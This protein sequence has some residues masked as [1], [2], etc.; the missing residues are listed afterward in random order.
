MPPTGHC[1]P[2]DSY[3]PHHTLIISSPS[4]HIIS[5]IKSINLS[6]MERLAYMTT[7]SYCQ[8]MVSC[9]NCQSMV[10][11]FNLAACHRHSSPW[12]KTRTQI[13][14]HLSTFIMHQYIQEEHHHHNWV[15]TTATGHRTWWNSRT[16]QDILH[17]KRIQFSLHS[18]VHGYHP[19]THNLQSQLWRRREN[20]NIIHIFLK[21]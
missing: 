17:N 21:L 1:Y 20:T 4:R 6:W 5:I 19:W 10:S 3:G 13:W 7:R 12:Y 15:N 2:M 11:Y 9:F 14:I 18:S 16:T 8:S